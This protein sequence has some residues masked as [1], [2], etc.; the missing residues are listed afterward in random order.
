M[1]IKVLLVTSEF[2]P[3]PGGIG[4][5][6]LHLSLQL[7]KNGCA[8][9][10]VCD[11]R[12]ADLSQ[13]VDFDSTLPV[14]VIRT[15]RQ[16][17]AVL[18][19]INRITTTF[20]L[21]KQHDVVVASGK[22]PLW[23]V[24]ICSLIYGSKKYVAV[25]HGSELGAGG[26]IS[27]ALTKWSLTRF[28]TLIAVS[29]FTKDLALQRSPKLHITVIN[30]GFSPKTTADATFSKTTHLSLITVGNV[31]FRKGQQNVIN[32]LPLLL[33]HYPNLIYNIVGLPTEKESFLALA[34]DLGVAH[35]VVFHG[36][37]SDAVLQQQLGEAHV[38]LM[39]SDHLSNGDVEGF[40]I[41][42]LEA[43]D[44]SLPGIGSKNS[45]IAD[46]IADGVSGKL[47]DPHEPEEI[48][49]A[50]EAIISDYE[51]YADRAKKWSERFYWE[52]VIQ[53]YL[54]VIAS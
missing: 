13:D 42:V 26:A 43:N 33:T 24:A 50:L 39:L 8:V 52:V 28:N 19:Y 20:S 18:T 47:V 5:H 12:A 53:D 40:G 21:I 2:P 34:K 4:N 10:V 15:K 6:A 9:T 45:G 51:Q 54:K 46:A 25:L 44:L 35:A 14:Q 29:Q 31:T 32:A 1:N 23:V 22:F 16:Q 27:V 36:A 48:L 17:P 11:Q 38:F 30:N 7:Q 3:Q 41:A 37:V 49:K